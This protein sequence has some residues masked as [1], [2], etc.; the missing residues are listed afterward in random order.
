MTREFA[1]AVLDTIADTTSLFSGRIDVYRFHADAGTEWWNKDVAEISRDGVV[2]SAPTLQEVSQN[3]M[4]LRSVMS[5][6]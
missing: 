1:S 4:V 6:S 5:A 3:A 2:F